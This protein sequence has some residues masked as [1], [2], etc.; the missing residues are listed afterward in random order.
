VSVVVLISLAHA[1]LLDS[2]DEPSRHLAGCQQAAADAESVDP[3]R[4]VG[5]W[6]A[7]LGEADR[8]GYAELLPGLRA[9]VAV[10]KAWAAAAPRFATDPHHAAMDVL[11]VAARWSTA[12]LSTDLVTRTFRGWMETD[13]GRAYVEDVRTVS[14]TWEGGPDPRVDEALRKAVQDVG[15][16]WVSPGDPAAD[17]LIAAHLEVSHDAGAASAQGQLVVTR[18]GLVFDKVRVRARDATLKGFTVSA[19]AESP[20]AAE[21]DAASLKV[22]AEAAARTLLHRVLGVLFKG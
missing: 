12:D 13:E 21:A 18:T 8:L 14:V 20:T 4:A 10:E 16:K 2:L 17:T 7:C 5:V 15:L 1:G 9:Q 6:E 11:A 22:S 3:Q 19:S